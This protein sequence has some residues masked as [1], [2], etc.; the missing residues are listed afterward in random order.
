MQV[1]NYTAAHLYCRIHPHS[2]FLG[3]VL[4]K[5][6]LGG[7]YRTRRSNRRRTRLQS[8]TIVAFLTPPRAPLP[9]P[10]RSLTPTS[11]PAA[12]DKLPALPR[13]LLGRCRRAAGRRHVSGMRVE[14]NSVFAL[15]Q[16]SSVALPFPLLVLG[17]W[18]LKERTCLRAWSL[19]CNR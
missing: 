17:A 2:H 6:N 3:G 11:T 4:E 18:A 13:K 9:H 7:V 8:N 1:L 19:A 5:V 10:L 16:G 12:D 14:G 15:R